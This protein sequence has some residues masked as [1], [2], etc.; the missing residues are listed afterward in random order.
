MPRG[1][2]NQPLLR[3]PVPDLA[4]LAGAVRDLGIR[5]AGTLDFLARSAAVVGRR[6]SRVCARAARLTRGGVQVPRGRTSAHRAE[7]L[8]LERR[9]HAR[10]PSADTPPRG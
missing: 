8:G 9:A 5:T 7:R 3:E 6:G 10:R 4:A 1:L 2:S